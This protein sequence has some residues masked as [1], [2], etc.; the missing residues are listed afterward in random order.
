MPLWP[1]LRV[2]RKLERAR[3]ADER[4]IA[5]MDLP[6]TLPPTSYEPAAERELVGVDY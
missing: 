1:Q 4:T 6:P 5:R 3:L 2:I